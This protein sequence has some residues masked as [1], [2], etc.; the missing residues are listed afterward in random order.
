MTTRS[1]SE[2]A[3]EDMPAVRGS[4]RRGVASATLGFF[5]GFA[6]V[7]LYGPVATELEGA[8]GLSGLALGLLVAAPQLTG[9]LLRIPFGAWVEDVG[10]AKPFLVLLSCAVVGM[11]GLSTILVTLGT[12]GL[13]MAHYPLVFLFGALSG[14]GIATFSV[15]AAQTSYWSP[16]DRQGTMLAVYA[17]LGNSSPGIFTLLVPIA[18]A[19]LGLTGAYL[20]W[21]GFL[22]L[23]TFVYGIVAV[24]PPSFQLRKQGLEAE[25]AK[26]AA[27]ARGQDLF[28]GGDAMA[29]IREAASIPRTWVL[30]ALFFTS[31]GGFLALTTWFPSYWTAVHDLD[32]QRAG[33][34]T[35]VAFTLLA[36]LIRVPGGV[37]SDRIGGE[38]TA[39][40]SF[41]VVGIAALGLM[42]ARTVPIAIGATVLLGIGI[43]VANAAVFGLVPKYVPEAVG[44]ASGLVGG[45]GA[46]GGFVIPPVLGLFVDLQGTAGYAN[47]YVVFLVLAIVSIGLSGGLYRTRVESTPNGP[48]PTDD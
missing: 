29:S 31:F 10:A 28:P 23:G 38:R 24:D 33:A 46:F 48:V 42:T 25:D 30:V 3:G 12:E 35:A 6:G 18:L 21:F 4:P 27:E 14:C 43:G 8:M 13:T 17:G 11:A 37:V 22:V 34:L 20:V 26:R 36:A 41:V 16:E 45:L 5:V 15:G 19:A 47:G 7:V 9:S 2:P 44:G 40:A 32:L 39:I 1:T